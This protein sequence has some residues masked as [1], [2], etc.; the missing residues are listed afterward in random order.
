M[1]SSSFALFTDM[2]IIYNNYHYIVV[3]LMLMEA[4]AVILK[5]GRHVCSLVDQK[6]NSMSIFDHLERFD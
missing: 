1:S 4:S 2:D 3:S 6:C 5:V